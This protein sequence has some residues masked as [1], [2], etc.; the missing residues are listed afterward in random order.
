MLVYLPIV[1]LHTLLLS[2]IDSR[3]LSFTDNV[4]E[5]T[6]R[7]VVTHSPQAIKRENLSRS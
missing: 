7:V 4:V 1:V 6:R 2:S 3:A 5:Q